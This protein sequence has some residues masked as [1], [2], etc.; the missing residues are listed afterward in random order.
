M[1]VA[2]VGDGDIYEFINFGEVIEFQQHRH[3]ESYYRCT[4]SCGKPY[5]LLKSMIHE[6]HAWWILD[7]EIL[8]ISG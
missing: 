7:E 8:G 6:S 3:L 4:T 5:R 2:Y 1:Q